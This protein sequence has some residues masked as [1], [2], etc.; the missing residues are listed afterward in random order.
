MT[1]YVFYLAN[2][3]LSGISTIIA[4]CNIRSPG[5]TCTPQKPVLLLLIYSV[6]LAE[7]QQMPVS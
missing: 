7:K 6:R 3:Q 1:M 2:P 4:R 5:T